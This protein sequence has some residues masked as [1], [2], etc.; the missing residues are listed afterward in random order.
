LNTLW[1]DTPTAYTGEQL[2]AHWIYNTT[3][4]LG[5]AMV[6]FAGPAHVS[7]GHMVD[8][9]DVRQNAP[10]ASAGMLHFLTE[11]YDMPLTTGIALQR[12][13]ISAIQQDLHLNYAPEAA[14]PVCTLRRQGNDLWWLPEKRKLSVAITT[15]TPTSIV[16]HTAFNL[17]RDGAP[18]PTI[19]LCSDFAVPE[20]AIP[21]L[22]AEW[23]GLFVQE[24]DSLQRSSWK[25]RAV[26]GVAVTGIPV[27]GVAVV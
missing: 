3:G 15:Q 9:E 10:I 20:K 4:L 12:L 8:L 25:V 17:T 11:L 16:M 27:S 22:A 7:L 6:A 13:W 5:P 21:Q 26:S 23:M 24:L 2:A 1:L 18:V 19:G 14:Q